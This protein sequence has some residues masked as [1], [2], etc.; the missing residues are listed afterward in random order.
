MLTFLPTVMLQKGTMF[1]E[2]VVLIFLPLVMIFLVLA[3]ILLSATLI[4]CLRSVVTLW[5][6]AEMRAARAATTTSSMF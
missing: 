6:G 3:I 1:L 5:P 2:F 4:T